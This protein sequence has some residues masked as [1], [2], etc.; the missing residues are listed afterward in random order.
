MHIVRKTET[1][2][3]PSTSLTRHYCPQSSLTLNQTA[4]VLANHLPPGGIRAGELTKP[5]VMIDTTTGELLI[6]LPV[7][8]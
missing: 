6:E 5:L 8:I 2:L 1:S 3:P 4:V 7:K